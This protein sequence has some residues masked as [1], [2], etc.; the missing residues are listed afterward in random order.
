MSFLKA[1]WRKL[2]LA[3]YAIDP[4]ILEPYVPARTELDIWNGNCYVSLVGFMFKN[5]KLLGLKI[6]FHVNFEEVNLR[7]YV[8]HFDGKEWK[9]GVTFVSEIVP[10]PAI[11]I[12]ANTIYKEH[13][14]TMPMRHKWDINQD[15][16]FI[17]Y[18]W[19]FKGNWQNFDLTTGTEGHDLV[20]GSEE[21]FITEHYWGYSPH[22]SGK[23]VEYQ[24]THPR[25]QT[26]EVKDFNIYADFGG[27]YGKEFAFLANSQPTSVMLAE[28]SQITVESRNILSKL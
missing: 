26:Y 10:K 9:R 7:F 18:Q 12:V 6:P 17:E 2:A 14:S 16:Q 23:T 5:V 24:V 28:G 15:R 11:S 20:E 22:P 19:K 25:W 21:E 13:Y 8:R 27:L 1:E 3:N 4:K